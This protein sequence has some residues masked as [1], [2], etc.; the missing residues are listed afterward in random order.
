MQTRIFHSLLLLLM[1]ALLFYACKKDDYIVGGAPENTNA[2]KNT[3]TYDVLKSNDLYDTLVQVIDAAGLTDKINESGTTFFAPTDF[4]IYAYMNTRTIELQNFN[5][6]AKFALD[7]LLY[8][9]KN[10]V[11]GTRDSLL[12]YLVKKPLTY[13]VLTNTGTLY[14]TE[15]PG[16]TVVVSYEYTKDDN[17]G[18]NN[19]VS[20]VPQLVYFTQLWH[21]YDLS[22]GNP[23]SA[24]TSKTGIRTLCKTSGIVTKNGVLNSLETSHTLFFYGTK[25]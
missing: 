15:L 16:D 13:D 1:P 23:A 7:S 24:I 21:H 10:N 9:V 17:Y 20:S 11:R 4:S 2:Y 18:Y 12:L 6:T 22:A 5:P 19:Q 8:Y 25:Q 14:P 3:S